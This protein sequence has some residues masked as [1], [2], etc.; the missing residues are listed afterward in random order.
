MERGFLSKKS[1]RGRGVKKKTLNASNIE[2]VMDGVV[3]SVIVEYGNAT[4]EVVSPVVVDETVAIEKLSYLE[5]T[6]V[7]G[8]FPSLPT[9]VTTSAGKSLYANVTGKPSRKKVNFHTLFTPEGN[10]IDVV[11]LVES[12]RTISKRFA[13]TAYGFFLE[14]RVACNVVVNF[15]RNTWG[16]YGLKFLASTVSGLMAYFVTILTPDS[17]RSCVVQCTLPAQGMRSI[18]S[19]V[20]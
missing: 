17:A 13:N 7:L 12:I 8:P 3:P 1:S 16:K 19:M 6:T 5:D 11:F 18:I 2:V 20:S 14:K 4:K 9:Q 15:V 10:G